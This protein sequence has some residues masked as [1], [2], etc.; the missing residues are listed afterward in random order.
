M[1]GTIIITTAKKHTEKRI[2]F[3]SVLA[4]DVYLW[5]PTTLLVQFMEEVQKEGHQ[6][7]R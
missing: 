5:E 7:E 3:D 4:P 1:I 6:S 2:E